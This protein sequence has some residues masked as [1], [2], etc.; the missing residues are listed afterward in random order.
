MRK[1]GAKAFLA[2]VFLTLAILLPLLGGLIF[3]SGWQ[4]GPGTAGREKPEQGC[5]WAGPGPRPISPCW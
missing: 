1:S 4:G 2:L 5:P 3:Y